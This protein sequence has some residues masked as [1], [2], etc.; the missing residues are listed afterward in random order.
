METQTKK[1]LDVALKQMHASADVPNT[2]NWSA[3]QIERYK[4]VYMDCARKICPDFAVTQANSDAIIKT[5]NYAMRIPTSGIDLNK[6]IWLYGDIG[7]GKSTLMSV[8]REFT[9][10]VGVKDQRGACAAAFG[11]FPCME[12]CM[13]FSKEG[14]DILDKHSKVTRAYDELGAEPKVTNYYGT[15]VNVFE[16]L[17]QIRYARRAEYVTHI[18]TN[19]S[20]PQVAERY[21]FRIEDRCV[22]MF[23]FI[24]MSGMSLRK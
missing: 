8:L 7:T 5:F 1:T 10:K 20:L 17:L 2:A 4:Q 18:T 22:E 21:G 6:G 23:N 16:Y 11:V 14:Y 24:E 19:M 12:V 3:T 13:Q 15:P 9:F